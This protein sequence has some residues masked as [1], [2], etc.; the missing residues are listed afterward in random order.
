MQRRAFLATSLAVTAPL[1]AAPRIQI[2]VT[3]WDLKMQSDPAS[4]DLA[5][6]IGFVGVEVSLGRVPKDGKLPLDNAEL[7]ARYLAKAQQTGMKLIS[8]CLDI[9]HVN[10]L[11]N[12]PLA[13]RWLG[14]AIEINRK[15]G[16]RSMLLPFFGARQ[17]ETIEEMAYVADLLKDF[18][19]QAEKAGVTLGLENTISAE[20]NIR[21]LDRAKSP[22]VKVFYDIGN[23]FV[24]GF[25]IYSEIGWLGKDRISQIH[26]KDNPN[27]LG[28]GRIDF[29]RV[30]AAIEATGWSGYADFE[31]V[32]PSKDVKADMTRNLNYL[33]G[34]MGS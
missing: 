15:M 9:L 30:L 2:G 5:K 14:D 28:A 18:G 7:Q 10:G 24:R 17:M 3:D 33:R 23:S 22:A 25:D 11:K 19:K 29:P 20:N 21:I 8:T 4:L 32:S 12:D 34:V 1:R 27:Y 13:Q 26:L 16:I 6:E 31:T